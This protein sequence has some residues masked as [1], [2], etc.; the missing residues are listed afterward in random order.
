MK[1]VIILVLVLGVLGGGGF[2]AY[3]MF[4]EQVGAFVEEMMKPAPKEIITDIVD[5]EPINLPIFEKGTVKRFY[6][7]QMSLET[8]RE[9]G[10]SDAARNQLP[11]IQNAFIQ[12]LR[13]LQESGL[14]PGFG[15]LDFMRERL[16][17][18]ANDVLGE[19]RV[20]SV[21]FQTIFERP[22]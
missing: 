4:P 3:T 9:T 2:A 12:Y 16:T 21:L 11:R 8:F 6:V 15:D 7:M 13:A 5:L 18:I 22:V 10:G 17:K 14:R 19:G 20:R 1:L